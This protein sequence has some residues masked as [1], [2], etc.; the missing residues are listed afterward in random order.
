MT[1]QRKSHLLEDSKEDETVRRPPYRRRRWQIGMALFVLSNIVGSTIQITTLPLPVLS[2]LQ[3]SGLVFNTAC[4]SVILGEPFTRWSLFGTLLVAA[5]AILIASFGAVP[6]PSHTLDQL[7]ELLG[8]EQFILWMIG[9]FVFM[10]FVVVVAFFLGRL[11]PEHSPRLRF[12]RGMCFGTL[13]GILSAHSLLVAKSAVELIVR[14]IVD[15]SNQFNR[16]QSWIILLA[17]VFFALTQ[18][19]FLH[20]GLKLCSTSVLYPFVFCIYNIIAILDGLIYFR[21]TSRLPSLHAGLI[22]VGTVILLSGVLA[23]SWRLEDDGSTPPA[24]AHTLLTPGMGIVED[25]TTE[26]ESDEFSTGFPDIETDEENAL[27][28]ADERTP[29]LK[30]KSA[31]DNE[32]LHTSLHFTKPRKYARIHKH[33]T[34]SPFRTNRHESDADDIWS[35]LQD[36]ESPH[37]A[38]RR[39]ASAQPGRSNVH[40]SDADDSS[41]P[42]PSSPSKRISRTDGTDGLDPEAAEPSTKSR[43]HIRAHTLTGTGIDVHIGAGIGASTTPSGAPTGGVN[44]SVSAYAKHIREQKRRRRRWSSRYRSASMS[45]AQ[46]QG[47]KAQSLRV[48]PDTPGGVAE[49]DQAHQQS[50]TG[51]RGWFSWLLGRR[52]EN[53]DTGH[54]TQ[55]VPTPL[56]QDSAYP[57]Q[58]SGEEGSSS[59]SKRK[60]LPPLKTNLP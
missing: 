2:T 21:Q 26:S 1:L 58:P 56:H 39:R 30:T 35:A 38:K 5:G 31:P 41:S 15:R 20:R 9:T 28:P 22:A 24:D 53:A 36:D 44:P 6:E 49:A 16:W 32:A 19:Y 12:W 29:L 43:R 10:V 23:L 4:A 8:R 14:T 34:F 51:I 18:L 47:L 17:L 7:L 42:T 60:R 27:L 50:Q 59:S 33:H 45:E 13:S 3:A 40:F 55:A 52:Q 46:K 25:T 11:H 57:G 48:A 37:D 54:E